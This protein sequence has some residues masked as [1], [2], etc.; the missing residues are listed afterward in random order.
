MSEITSFERDP[1]ARFKA[2]ARKVYATAPGRA[3]LIF[4][5]DATASRQPTWDLACHLQAQMFDAVEKAGGL[6]VQ[7]VHFRG[8]MPPSYSGFMG[9]TNMLKR[10][11]ASIRCMA[12]AT[13]IG[14]VLSHITV[15]NKVQPVGA[16]IY[17]GDA[18]EESQQTV[19][20]KAAGAGVKGF[21]FHEDPDTNHTAVGPFRAM[22]AATGG[23]Y[24]PF[25]ESSL[26]ML[27]DLLAGVA[28]YA[29]GGK[30]L[31]EK[32]KDAASRLLLSKL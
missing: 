24:L 28:R 8:H 20:D 3:R 14:G 15:T 29:V 22:A 7:L 2:A 30:A 27:G 25:D 31:L 5:L 19:V 10:S 18:F 16:F 17:I 26:G 13:Q 9:D 4:A 23:V 32:Q 11:M 6:D 1:Y 21:I 12:G